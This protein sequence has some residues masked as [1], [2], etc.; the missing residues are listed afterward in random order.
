MLMPVMQLK[1]VARGFGRMPG[2]GFHN[3]VDMTAPYGSAVRAAA[4]GTVVF[5]GTYFGYGQMIDIVSE[6]G[7]VTRYAHLSAFT[8]GLRVGSAVITGATIGAI[9]TSG[10][11]HGPHLHFEVRINGVAVDPKPSLAL[12][13]CVLAPAPPLEEARAPETVLRRH[14]N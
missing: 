13:P 11:A 8:R 9:G 5:A 2:G 10:Q 3:G 12:A 7:V 14:P 1:Q 6:S 4:G